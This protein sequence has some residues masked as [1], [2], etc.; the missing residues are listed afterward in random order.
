MATRTLPAEDL[1]DQL[2]LFSRPS[3]RPLWS[4]LPESTQQRLTQ[5][6]SEMISCHLP[7]VTRPRDQKAEVT[8]E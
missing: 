8:D 7:V 4:D 5:L 6:L 2:S 3:P 1:P